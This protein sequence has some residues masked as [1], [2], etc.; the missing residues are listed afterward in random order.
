MGEESCAPGCRAPDP[1]GFRRRD[2]PAIPG[3]LRRLVVLDAGRWPRCS[4]RRPNSDDGAG[5]LRRGGSLRPGELERSRRANAR[6]STCWP[7]ESRLRV[8]WRMQISSKRS[9]TSRRDLRKARRF[10]AHRA[11]TIGHPKRIGHDVRKGEDGGDTGGE[12]EVGER[13]EAWMICTQAGFPR[14]WGGR[15]GRAGAPRP[16]TKTMKLLANGTARRGGVAALW[17]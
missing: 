15:N 1:A 6:S 16:A 4:R 12:T 3:P 8:A 10:D 13:A 14:N 2:H 7:K 5:G 11:V 17:V 9:S